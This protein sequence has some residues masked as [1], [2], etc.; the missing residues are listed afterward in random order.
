[1]LFKCNIQALVSCNH[2]T[3]FF[4]TPPQQN[5]ECFIL[6]YAFSQVLHLMVRCQGSQQDVVDPTNFITPFLNRQWF[7][8]WTMWVYWCLQNITVPKWYQY[9]V[10]L[11]AIPLCHFINV[12]FHQCAIPPMCHSTYVPFLLCAIPIPPFCHSAILPFCYSFKMP[13]RHSAILPFHQFAITPI[14]LHSYTIS[15][16]TNVRWF[17]GIPNSPKTLTA[18][19]SGAAKQ[20]RWGFWRRSEKFLECV[21]GHVH[22]WFNRAKS[23]VHIVQRGNWTT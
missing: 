16:L 13:F 11:N 2:L 4:D 20:W 12:P 8:R 1:M 14:F 3:R 18:D 9:A 22:L 10:P 15:T 19:G 5:C 17:M 21:S 7:Q 23:S 6:Y